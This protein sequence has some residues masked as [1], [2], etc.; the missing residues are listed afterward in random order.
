MY[1]QTA[2]SLSSS[3]PREAAVAHVRGHFFTSVWALCQQT[4]SLSCGG[5]RPWQAPP[6]PLVDITQRAPGAGQSA[7]R[8]S[9]SR[10]VYGP[11]APTETRTIADKRFRSEQDGSVSVRDRVDFGCVQT[12]CTVHVPAGGV[13]TRSGGSHRLSLR[14]DSRPAAAR[15]RHEH[16]PELRAAARRLQPAAAALRPPAGTPESRWVSA[17]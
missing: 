4:C 14:A 3:S 10:T 11:S 2:A 17:V 1:L 8:S 9:C 13:R 7:L 5:G 6:L 12:R 15:R 16:L